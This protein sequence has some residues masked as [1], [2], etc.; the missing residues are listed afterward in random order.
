[1]AEFKLPKGK[2]HNRFSKSVDSLSKILA[3]VL[4]GLAI[5]AAILSLIHRH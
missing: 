4:Q 2:E 1:M 5:V 3:L